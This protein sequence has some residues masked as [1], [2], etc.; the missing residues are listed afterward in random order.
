MMKHLLQSVMKLLSVRG[1]GLD[2]DEL[3]REPTEEELAEARSYLEAYDIPLPESWAFERFDLSDGAYVRV[4]RA[5]PDNPRA[6]LLYVPSYTSS[7]ELVS[8]FLSHWY[9]LGFEVTAMDLPGQGGSIRRDD[10]YQKPYTGDWSYYGRS[11]SEVATHIE[12]TR[13]SKGPLV[14]LGESMGGHSV[15]RAAHD[16]G[17]KE[18]DALFL[19]VPAILPHTKDRLPLLGIPHL[20]CLP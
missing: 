18:A 13:E 2:F 8:E 6:T 12:A 10:D 1:A 16:G 19:M 7:Q 20:T 11:V 5:V 3:V 14:V 15:L 4:G 17:L 9:A